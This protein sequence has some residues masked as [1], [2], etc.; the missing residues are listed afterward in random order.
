MILT[1]R[2]YY[3]MLC[4]QLFFLFY[5]SLYFIFPSGKSPLDLSVMSKKTIIKVTC[6]TIYLKHN[7]NLS[8]HQE[9]VFG[10]KKGM[11]GLSLSRWL[12]LALSATDFSRIC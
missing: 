9:H 2:M 11:E 10:D 4:Q 12:C 8:P 1:H 5:F 3:S 7:P 6:Y